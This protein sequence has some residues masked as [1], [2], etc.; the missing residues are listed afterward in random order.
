MTTELVGGHDSRQSS[1]WN[2]FLFPF[3]ARREWKRRDELAFKGEKPKIGLV[4]KLFDK[5]LKLSGLNQIGSL[6]RTS[7]YPTLED[8]EEGEKE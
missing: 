5:T 1:H 7:S 3:A 8:E 4:I 6:N 2:H